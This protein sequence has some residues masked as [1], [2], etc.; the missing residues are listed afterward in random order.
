MIKTITHIIILVLL[1]S[2]TISCKKEADT[3]VPLFYLIVDQDHAQTTDTITLT[4]EPEEKIPPYEKY[5]SRWDWNGDTIFDTYFIDDLEVKFRFLKPGSQTVFCEVLGIGGGKAM[6]SIKIEIEQ[7]Y[8]APIANLRVIPDSGNFT[9]SFLLDASLSFDYED[10]LSELEFRW[11]LD[12][13]GIYEIP[14]SSCNSIAHIFKKTGDNQVKVEV[15][16]P[17]N[18]FNAMT[19]TVVVHKTDTC[20]I[21]AFTWK[22]KNGRVNDTIY[23][24]ATNSYRDDSPTDFFLYKWCFDGEE[25]TEF[26]EDPLAWHQYNSPGWK[27]VELIVQDTEGLEN[28]LKREL[29]VAVENLPPR[30]SIKTPTKYGNVTTQFYMNLTDSRDDYTA[31]SK[32]LYRWDFDGDG[33]WDTE[34]NSD[35]E[36]YHQYTEPGVYKC[37]LE[38]ED[39]EGYKGTTDVIFHVNQHTYQTGYLVDSRDNNYYGTVKIG[40]NW[41]MSKNL[42]WRPDATKQELNMIQKCYDEDETNC[43]KYGSLYLGPYVKIYEAAGKNICPAGWH[44]PS[45]SDMDDLMAHIPNNNSREAILPGGI[46]GLDAQYAGKG[47]Y[48]YKYSQSDPTLVTDTIWEFSNLGVEGHIAS[49]DHRVDFQVYNLQFSKE[50]PMAW[51]FWYPN[52][53]YYYSIRCVKD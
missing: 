42:D 35:Q 9:T 16:D 17:S 2:T 5:H 53:H 51:M 30:P 44:V 39:E 52:K 8:S 34:Q 19:K 20:I 41:W 6:N 27:T 40:N 1:I 43:D 48:W 11:D 37:I 33:A 23:F 32:L 15:K 26:S 14:F 45:R 7:G 22:S 47:N 46:T 21:P 29:Y 25:F 3:H 12:D 18:R 10:S 28:S 13:D 24:D 36:I 31:T 49:G 4:I 38:A 50:T